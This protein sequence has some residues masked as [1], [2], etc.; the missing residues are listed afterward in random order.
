MKITRMNDNK[1]LTKVCALLKAPPANS[2]TKKPNANK[3]SVKISRANKLK[4][5]P[6]EP[7][8]RQHKVK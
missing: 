8:H 1:Y 6:G 2:A 7:T 5:R 4:S 3:Y